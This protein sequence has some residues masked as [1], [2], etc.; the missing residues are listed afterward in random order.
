MTVLQVFTAAVNFCLMYKGYIGVVNVIAG[1]V[2]GWL[3]LMIADT[4][5]RLLTEDPRRGFAST[6]RFFGCLISVVAIGFISYKFWGV[7]AFG[8][9]LVKSKPVCLLSGIVA[10]VLRVA[11]NISNAKERCKGHEEEIS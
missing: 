11:Y 5:S 8:F 10:S 6:V 2:Y 7:I 9:K 3:I 4:L 1:T